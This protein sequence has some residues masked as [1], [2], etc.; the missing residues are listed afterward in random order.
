MTL[1]A[2]IHVPKHSISVCF[3]KVHA[4][5]FAEELSFTFNETMNGKGFWSK[6]DVDVDVRDGQMYH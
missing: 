4:A 2:C 1:P 6:S 5:Y 3:A